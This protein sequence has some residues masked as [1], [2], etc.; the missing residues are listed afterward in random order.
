MKHRHTAIALNVV[1][2]QALGFLW[3]SEMLF[4][5]PWSA[6]WLKTS[7]D[8]DTGRLAPFIFAILASVMLGYAISW[9]LILTRAD[10]L[11]KALKV[12]GVAWLSFFALHLL[13]HYSFMNL[14][15]LV[16]AIDAGRE[17]LSFTSTAAVLVLLRK[18]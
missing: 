18:K 8:L 7:A 17:L 13:T 10:N 16:M 14:P 6:G 15:P 1:L 11:L 3:Y 12:A 2:Q 5:A 4:Y 9:L